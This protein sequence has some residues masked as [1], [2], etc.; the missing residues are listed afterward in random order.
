MGNVGKEL[1]GWERAVGL[2]RRI[3]TEEL[4]DNQVA[5]W[6]PRYDTNGTNGLVLELNGW[7]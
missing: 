3:Q 5:W 2:H 4:V 1:R 6:K 7:L